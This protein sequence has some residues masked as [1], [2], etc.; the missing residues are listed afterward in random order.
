MKKPSQVLSQVDLA[1]FYSQLNHDPLSID[2]AT[3]AFAVE[4]SR[5]DPRLAEITCEFIRDYWWKIDT[6][7]LNKKLQKIAWPEAILPMIE[8]I[9]M[10]CKGSSQEKKEF[11]DWARLAC[12]KIQNE[13]SQLY[14]FHSW[15]P[16]SLRLERNILEN[17]PWF[18]KHHFIS[19]ETFFN[20]DNPKVL[21]LG[22]KRLSEKEKLKIDVAEFVRDQIKSRGIDVIHA[23]HLL[24]TDK[25]TIS[26]INRLMIKKLSL[27]FL[28]DIKERLQA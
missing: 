18:K 21:S 4:Q 7:N 14:F 11:C 13:S 10:R 23:A 8:E 16:D 19:S 22:K 26:Q 25:T 6:E 15:M 1:H 28:Y 3:L 17:K 5:L 12:A 27:D 20:K 24:Q 9:K 2:G